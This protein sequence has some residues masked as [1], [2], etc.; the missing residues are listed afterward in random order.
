MNWRGMSPILVRG[1][2]PRT[3]TA[4]SPWKTQKNTVLFLH[5]ERTQKNTV[6]FQTTENTEEHGLPHHGRTRKDTEES[7]SVF[8]SFI[9]RNRAAPCARQIS[10]G[11]AWQ[12][13]S[14]KNPLIPSRGKTTRCG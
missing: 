1:A 14:V 11:R 4:F 8:S 12:M 7:E 5:H 10:R 6:L 3:T 2:R 13:N 9:R